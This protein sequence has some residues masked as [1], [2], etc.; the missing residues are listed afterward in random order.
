[1]INRIISLFSSP[2][3]E[4]VHLYELKGWLDNKT[5]GIYKR[6]SGDLSFQYGKVNEFL[7]KLS[8]QLE[9]L[10]TADIAD[11]DQIEHRVKQVVLSHKDSYVKQLQLL[12]RDLQA[13]EDTNFMIA[14][15][16]SED[17]LSRLD[18][19]AKNTTK[20]F[21]ASQHLFYKHTEPIAKSIASVDKHLNDIKIRIDESDVALAKEIH[22]SV[23]DLQNALKKQDSVTEQ[24]SEFNSRLREEKLKLD[25]L[26]AELTA[27]ADSEDAKVYMALCEKRK[28]LFAKNKQLEDDVYQ[29][30]SPLERGFR[31][32]QN[33]N[34]S[35]T[36]TQY[37]NDPVKAFK[38]DVNKEIIPILAKLKLHDLKDAIYSKVERAIETLSVEKINQMRLEFIS[39]AD[40]I[41]SLNSEIET[42]TFSSKNAKMISE[43]SKL[44]ENLKTISTE[45]DALGEIDFDLDEKM[46]ILKSNLRELT[47][48]TID[49]I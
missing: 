17:S 18:D 23:D 15:K 16:Y 34:T 39:L 26:K 37:I 42:N 38:Q 35:D 48:I 31:K 36:L 9:E 46:E 41:T 44:E 21:S 5:E 4:K 22:D 28:H 19:F 3:T 40:E 13:P 29:L 49:I 45:I 43:I 24:K 32:E 33:S 10:N 12:C 14:S 30:L 20:S 25:N 7:A 8:A 27:F 11:A 6:L 47:N 1:M 2:K